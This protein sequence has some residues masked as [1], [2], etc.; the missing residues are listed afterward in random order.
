MRDM[1]GVNRE[2]VNDEGVNMYEEAFVTF[3]RNAIDGGISLFRDYSGWTREDTLQL[4]ERMYNNELHD[5]LFGP[6][7]VS[8]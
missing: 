7:E 8:S 6:A 4:V 1:K 2:H 3:Y 5:W